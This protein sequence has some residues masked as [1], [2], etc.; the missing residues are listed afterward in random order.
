MLN[1]LCSIP[2]FSMINV[3]FKKPVKYDFSFV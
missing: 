1:F 2:D 3:F